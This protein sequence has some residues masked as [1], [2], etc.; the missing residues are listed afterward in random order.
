MASLSVFFRN[1]PAIIKGWSGHTLSLTR[2]QSDFADNLSEQGDTDASGG[3][4]LTRD[5][6]KRWMHTKR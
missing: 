4:K 3:E 5:A 2:R 1:Y 6:G